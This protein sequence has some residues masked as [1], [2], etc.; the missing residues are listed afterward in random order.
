MSD[1]LILSTTDTPDLAQKI[2]S[3]LVQ[4]REA[5]CVS[6][7][8]GIR[9]VYVWEGKEC[10]ERECLLLIKSTSEKFEAVRARIR[11]LHSYQVPEIIAVPVTA[12]DPSYLEW[13]H[14]SLEN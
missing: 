3:A 8:P 1:L 9:S 12:G 2:A 6:I 13:L 4:A 10:D 11:Q 5:A 14:S 7:V